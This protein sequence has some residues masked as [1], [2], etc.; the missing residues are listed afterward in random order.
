M[1]GQ[2]QP[3]CRT[4]DDVFD[5]DVVHDTFLADYL[6]RTGIPHTGRRPAWTRQFCTEGCR[7]TAVRRRIDDTNASMARR[8]SAKRAAVRAETGR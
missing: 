3:K 1:T 2:V 8:R 6:D 7:Y 5:P 4:C